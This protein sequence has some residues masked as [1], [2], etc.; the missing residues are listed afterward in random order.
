MVNAFASVGGASDT[1]IEE[2]PIGAGPNEGIQFKVIALG[3]PTVDESN[4]DS[5]EQNKPALF[6]FNPLFF[7]D[8]FNQKFDKELRREGQQCRGEDVSIKN[9]KNS[10]FHATGVVLEE[11]LRVVQ[12]LAEHDGV[13]DMI[14]PIS[15]NGGMECYIKGGDVGE[16]EGWN[17]V[18]RQWMFTYTLDFV[19]TGLDEFGNDTENDLVSSIL[20]G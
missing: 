2:D 8:R 16:V 11:N 3:Q 5:S 10:E 12:K 19:S 6:E 4:S 14:T 17:P 13:V 15:P 18:A 7:P 1:Y 9:L 20:D